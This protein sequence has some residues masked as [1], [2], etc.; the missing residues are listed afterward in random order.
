MWSGV[1][2]GPISRLAL[3]HSGFRRIGHQIGKKPRTQLLLTSAGLG[4]VEVVGNACWLMVKNVFLRL[5][6]R[7]VGVSFTNIVPEVF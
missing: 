5:A 1:L 3:V 6:G 4:A 7:N 2:R